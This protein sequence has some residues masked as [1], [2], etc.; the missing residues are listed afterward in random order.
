MDRNEK[1]QFSR[2]SR[3]NHRLEFNGRTCRPCRVSEWASERALGDFELA[4]A[5]QT[6]GRQ[7]FNSRAVNRNLRQTT[8]N[9]MGAKCRN[10][11][12][13]RQLTLALA[14]IQIPTLLGSTKLNKAKAMRHTKKEQV[15]ESLLPFWGATSANAETEHKQAIGPTQR[16]TFPSGQ[17]AARRKRASENSTQFT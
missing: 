1:S 15:R 11:M 4:G 16:R 13:R 12:T 5:N 8:L 14:F 7:T 17:L 6:I 3:S 10:Q 2:R 9:S